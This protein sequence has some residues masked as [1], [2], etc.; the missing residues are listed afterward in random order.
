MGSQPSVCTVIRRMIPK[1]EGAL[2]WW[3]PC[4]NEDAETRSNKDFARLIEQAANDRMQ[5]GCHLFVLVDEGSPEVTIPPKSNSAKP[6]AIAS[7]DCETCITHTS[8]P[9]LPHLYRASM[10]NNS[11]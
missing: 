8:Y 1:D 2:H 6:Q 5:G 10:S 3:D 9:Y 4:K 7:S 11:A